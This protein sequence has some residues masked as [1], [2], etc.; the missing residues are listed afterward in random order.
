MRWSNSLSLPIMLALR[1]RSWTI[2]TGWP[3]HDFVKASTWRHSG[4]AAGPGISRNENNAN[5]NLKGIE[6]KLIEEGGHALLALTTAH[7]W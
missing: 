6:V 4:K 1:Q 3:K 5:C 2:Y 7:Y